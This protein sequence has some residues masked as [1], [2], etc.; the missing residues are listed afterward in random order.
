MPDTDT[1]HPGRPLYTGRF[2]G[3]PADGRPGTSRC[4]SGILLVDRGT[5]RVWV[6]DFTPD[7]G[8]ET[9]GTFTARETTGREEDIERRWKAASEPYYDVVAAGAVLNQQEAQP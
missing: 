4:P 8:S 6:Y 3:G 5:S 9:S 7:P 1:T 2:A